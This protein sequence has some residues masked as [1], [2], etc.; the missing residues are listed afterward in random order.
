MA[1]EASLQSSEQ[2]GTRLKAGA[3]GL[4][5][6]TMQAVATIDDAFAAMVAGFG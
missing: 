5:G 2:G 3:I 4:G 1:T 6:A